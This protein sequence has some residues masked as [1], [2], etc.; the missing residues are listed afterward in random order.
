[1]DS[2]DPKLLGETENGDWLVPVRGKPG[3]WFGLFNPR[4]PLHWRY[5]LRSRRKVR[6]AMIETQSGHGADE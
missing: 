4:N 6:L 2:T 1:M 5:W 3:E